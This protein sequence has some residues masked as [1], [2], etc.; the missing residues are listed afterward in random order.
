[1]GEQK[2]SGCQSSPY[3]LGYSVQVS[4]GAQMVVAGKARRNGA[5]G[6][7]VMLPAEEFIKELKKRGFTVSEEVDRL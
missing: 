4:I 5:N 1:M 6:V 7:E 3:P 2:Q